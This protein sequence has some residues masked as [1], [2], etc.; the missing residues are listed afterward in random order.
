MRPY[1]QRSAQDQADGYAEVSSYASW[2]SRQPCG[3]HEA[4]QEVDFERKFKA[5]PDQ[6]GTSDAHKRTQNQKG[7]S[8]IS[9]SSGQ[10]DGDEHHG[11]YGHERQD[12]HFQRRQNAHG[13]CQHPRDGFK[14]ERNR[15][16]V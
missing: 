6:A 7:G 16:Y 5:D 12:S 1:G 14:N 10:T 9:I 15:L 3:G 2:S 4:G 8:W 13:L 11:K